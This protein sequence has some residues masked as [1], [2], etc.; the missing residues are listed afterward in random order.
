[1]TAR[2]P[3][4]RVPAR[5]VVDSQA[6]LPKSS[7]LVATGNVKININNEKTIEVPVG[8]KLLGALANAKLFVGS[9]CG[10]GST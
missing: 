9:A 10:G 4:P 7:K 3:G 1:M 2:P 5:V 8:G 6:R